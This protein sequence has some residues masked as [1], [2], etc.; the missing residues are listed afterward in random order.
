MKVRVDANR[1]QGH[2]L[3]AIAAESIFSFDDDAGHAYVEDEAADVPADMERAVTTAAATCPEQ[4]IVIT[5]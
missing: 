3:C 4:A 1:C 2:T 5:G